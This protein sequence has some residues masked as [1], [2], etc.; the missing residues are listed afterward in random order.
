MH[1]HL[2]SR[3]QGR[4]AP[5]ST[6]SS[7][8]LDTIKVP[9]NFQMI[10]NKLPPAQYNNDMPFISEDDDVVSVA[11]SRAPPPPPPPRPPPSALPQQLMAKAPPSA[12][13][14]ASRMPPPVLKG[15]D[16]AKLPAIQAALNRC[17][18]GGRAAMERGW[19]DEG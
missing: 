8:L 17:V 1:W 11:P 3:A 5:P 6:A 19:R 16:P 13:S 12:Q 9:R 18:L 2:L 4:Q 10:K 7:V 14:A 15:V